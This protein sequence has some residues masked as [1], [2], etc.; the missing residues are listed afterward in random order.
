[1]A[2]SRKLG[3]GMIFLAAVIWYIVVLV[4]LGVAMG[5]SPTLYAMTARFAA[6]RDSRHG[7]NLRRAV[8]VGVIAAVVSLFLLGGGTALALQQVWRLL[9]YN[10]LSRYSFIAAVGVGLMA[11]GLSRLPRRGTTIQKPRVPKPEGRPYVK[12]LGVFLFSFSKTAGSV[13]GVWAAF[14]VYSMVASYNLSPF[15]VWLVML[16]IVCVAAVTPFILVVGSK[17]IAPALHERS[18]EALARVRSSIARFQLTFLYG[19]IVSGA[20]LVAYAVI[21]TIFWLIGA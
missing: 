17:H 13:S 16:P 12:M 1:M 6:I 5:F 9:G 4:F 20:S 10:E 2:H 15:F 21:A 18:V 7:A 3:V 19:V 8:V 11:Y 14:M